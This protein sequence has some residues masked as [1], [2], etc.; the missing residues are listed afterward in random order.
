[1]AMLKRIARFIEGCHVDDS[2]VA[3][4]VATF[5]VLIGMAIGAALG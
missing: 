3:L 2:S 5:L 4:G 1:M